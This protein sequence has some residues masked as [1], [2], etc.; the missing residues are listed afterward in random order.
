MLR[1]NVVLRL[2]LLVVLVTLKKNWI[3]ARCLKEFPALQRLITGIQG[4]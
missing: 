2:G 1:V 3:I 4:D